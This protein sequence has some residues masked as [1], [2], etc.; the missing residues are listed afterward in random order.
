M[1]FTIACSHTKR[2]IDG[3]FEIC[4]SRADFEELVKQLRTHLA[5]ESWSF[6][7]ASIYPP[8]NIALNTH[9]KAWDD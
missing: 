9:T 4:G 7:W 5:D 6:G 1:K 8:I 3:A 2:Q